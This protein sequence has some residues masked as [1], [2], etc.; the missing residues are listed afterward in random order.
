MQYVKKIF[1][2]QYKATINA[3]FISK[4]VIKDGNRIQLQL[5]D[6]VGSEKYHSLMQTYIRNSEACILVF[7]LTDKVS[8]NNIET[9][10]KE[11]LNALNPPDG[12]EFP[13]V[14]AGNKLDLKDN[15][16]VKEEDI[17]NYC[18]MNNNM[19]YFLCSAQTGK[20]VDLIFDK[21]VDLA[22]ARYKKFNTDEFI[23]KTKIE[24]KVQKTPEKKCCF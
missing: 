18:D 7:D 5:W 6:T 19:P 10:R 22:L 1:G 3:D 16:K 14:L 20:N 23:P 17:Q 15:I 8:F 24:I 21:I 9:W 2:V 13:F 12:D 4:E 11:F